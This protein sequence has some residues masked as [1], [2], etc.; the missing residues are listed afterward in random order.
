[1]RK[2]G[3]RREWSGMGIVR[4]WNGRDNRDRTAAVRNRALAWEEMKGGLLSTCVFLS[5]Y[6]SRPFQRDTN[7]HMNQLS[8]S[9]H[10]IQVKIGFDAK[11]RIVVGCEGLEQ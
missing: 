11:G 5:L 4:Y 10:V 8:P 2:G 1:M 9:R 7:R 6:L 3:D